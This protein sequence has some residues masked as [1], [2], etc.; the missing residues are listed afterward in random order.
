MPP[1]LALTAVLLFWAVPAR[2]D[3]AAEVLSMF[4][5][6][7]ARSDRFDPGLAELYADDAA[8]RSKRVLPGGRTETMSLSGAQW[9]ALIRQA[10][11]LAKERGDRNTFRNVAAKPSGS[12]VIVTAERFS[13]LKNYASPFAQF[14]RKDKSGAWKIGAELTETRP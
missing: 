10:M 13:H 3:D 1:A 7:V 12:D 9:K 14:W 2:A 5:E 11:P 4:K 6:Y 8:I